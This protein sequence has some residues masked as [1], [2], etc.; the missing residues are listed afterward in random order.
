ML[1]WAL[2]FRSSNARCPEILIVLPLTRP[3]S[4]G[5]RNDSSLFALHNGANTED[6]ELLPV[7]VTSSHLPWTSDNWEAGTPAVS[8]NLSF[9]WIQAA[10]PVHRVAHAPL[11]TSAIT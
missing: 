10:F 2:L 11:L 6:S 1:S 9:G 8:Q 5:A 7:P 4:G 3:V